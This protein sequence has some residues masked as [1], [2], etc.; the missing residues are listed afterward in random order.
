MLPYTTL[1]MLHILQV[2]IIVPKLVP[3]VGVEPTV[4][5]STLQGWCNRPLCEVGL[6][7]WLPAQ[8]S[9][10]YHEV[11][12]LVSYLLDDP[13]INCLARTV[14]VEPTSPLQRLSPEGLG[15]FLVLCERI[16]LPTSCLRNKRTTNC[17]NR[18][19]CNIRLCG[20]HRRAF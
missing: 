15:L 8:G 3:T 11:Q 2:C 9:N 7:V 1:T 18:A 6:I 19:K 12:G 20:D 4:S 5:C 17:A 14:G 16:E 13:E 10:L